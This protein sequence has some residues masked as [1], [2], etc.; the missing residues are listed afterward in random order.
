[1]NSFLRLATTAAVALG[2]VLTV[3]AE[4]AS[5]DQLIKKL[6]SPE[7]VVKADPASLDPLAKQTIDAIKKMNF[8]N[9]YAT[10]KKLAARYPKSAGAHSVHGQLALLL[11]RYP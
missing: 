7:K 11:R 3:R 6:P 8:G 5:V 9:A 1:M 4:D 2:I 10:S